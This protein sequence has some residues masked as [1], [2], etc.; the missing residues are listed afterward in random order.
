MTPAQRIIKYGAIAFAIFLIAAIVSG[1]V[2][3]ILFIVGDDSIAEDP[4]TIAIS[5]DVHSLDLA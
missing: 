5:E 1:A 2:S 4:V 3:V